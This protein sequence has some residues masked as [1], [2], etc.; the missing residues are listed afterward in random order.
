MIL[1]QFAPDLSAGLFSGS[2]DDSGL[3][4][5]KEGVALNNGIGSPHESQDAS[6][7]RTLSPVDPLAGT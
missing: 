2:Q 6:T 4:I 1:D 3:N 5:S 7:L